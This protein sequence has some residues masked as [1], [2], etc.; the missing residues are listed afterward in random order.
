[1]CWM[2]MRGQ[3]WNPLQKEMIAWYFPSS[4]SMWPLSW[5]ALWINCCTSADVFVWHVTWLITMQ[6]CWRNDSWI[7]VDRKLVPSSHIQRYTSSWQKKSITFRAKSSDNEDHFYKGQRFRATCL[8][9][10][11]GHDRSERSTRWTQAGIVQFERR[12]FCPF[13]SHKISDVWSSK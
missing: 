10:R 12:L 11:G 3:Y 6:E 4:G 13:K 5:K 8:P 9:A 2:G 7:A 1:M